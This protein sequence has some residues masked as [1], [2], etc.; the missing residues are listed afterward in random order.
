MVAAVVAVAIAEAA[1]PITGPVAPVTPVQVEGK[2]IVAI[3][4]ESLAENVVVAVTLLDSVITIVLFDYFVS[5][6]FASRISIL[7]EEFGCQVVITPAGMDTFTGMCVRGVY[8][9]IQ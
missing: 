8:V 9:V 6:V 7:T 5:H 2:M 3:V 4:A 1:T